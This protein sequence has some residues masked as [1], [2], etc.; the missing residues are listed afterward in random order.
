MR[1]SV[2]I[3]KPARHIPD[4]MKTGDP[5]WGVIVKDLPGE[6]FY[7]VFVEGAPM[8]HLPKRFTGR[9]YRQGEKIMAVISATRG[10]RII[11]SQK[12]SQYFR[13]VA[14]E[15]LL[16]VIRDGKVRVRHAATIVGSS[17]AKV[18]VEGLGNTDPLTACLPY[19]DRAKE[20]TPDTITIVRYSTDM[21]EY[22]VNS[23][24]PAPVSRVVEVIYSHGDREAVIKVDPE[25]CGLF[26]GKRGANVATAAKLLG[27]KI[28]IETTD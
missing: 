15:I 13:R 20:H 4:E 27:I 11:L 12:S 6:Y 14:E 22:I 1:T 9:C 26:V 10:R 3:E 28:T 21:R 19:L 7:R 18:A 23:L 24:V 5:V 17:F 25:Y 16:P 8:A 2:F